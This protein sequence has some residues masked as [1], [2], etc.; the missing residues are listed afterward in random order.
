LASRDYDALTRGAADADS[1]ATD[2]H[3]WL[4]V[5]YD[6]G[7]AFVR[8]ANALRSATSMQAAYLTG[9]DARE[10]MHWTPEASRRARGVEVWAALASLGR[11]GLIELI[12]RTCRHARRFADA[13][14]AA[15][16]EVRNDVVL[17]QVLVSFGDDATTSRV[18][19]HVQ[20]DRSCWCGGTIWKGRAA[21]RISVSSWATTDADVDLSVAAIIRAARAVA[22]RA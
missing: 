13:L 10:P 20:R 3:K 6:C 1:W 17:N 15:G 12:D 4:N 9:G 14:R 16:H 22:A 18:I 21:M 11:R 5:P 19:E 2:A 7:V 8:D